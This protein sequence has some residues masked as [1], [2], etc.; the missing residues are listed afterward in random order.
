[1]TA[2]D[3]SLREWRA[4]YERRRPIIGAFVEKLNLLFDELLDDYEWS[5]TWTDEPIAFV[6][7]VYRARR[8]GVVFED[9]IKEL[10]GFAGLGIV[11]ADA[12]RATLAA[13]T[14]ER[15]LEV[16]EDVSILP[17][18][19][20]NR[21]AFPRYFVSIPPNWAELSEW[22]PYEGLSVNVDVQ[23]LLQYALERAES[24]L[25]YHW[26][27][28]YPESVQEKLV[29]YYSLVA[30]ADEC[31]DGIWPAIEAL[32]SRYEESVLRGDLDVA[33]DGDSLVAYLRSSDT[34]AEH[35]R[36]G[37]A[38]GLDPDD[39]YEVNHLTVEQGLL[40]VLTRHE[41][42]TLRELDDFLQGAVTR[43][44]EVLGDIVRLSAEAGLELAAAPDLIV[45]WLVL[46]LRRADPETIQLIRYYQQ[47]ED[48]L[49]ILIGNPIP[50]RRDD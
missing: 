6:Q 43:A 23:T 12:T 22:K 24:D 8:A 3:S 11:L 18:E 49:N 1:M 5:Y 32:R 7:R 28:S 36:I 25:P 10:N 34:V 31:F 29:E 33:V 2:P 38:A 19:G 4:V 42:E 9:P 35:V 46:V 15:E 41:I 37:I 39:D 50:S 13:E 20:A 14:V 16:N 21:P 44:S 40:W 45:E 17:T 48:A 26:R 30:A 27:R 47:L